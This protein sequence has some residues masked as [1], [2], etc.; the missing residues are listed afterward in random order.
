[1]HSTHEAELDIPSLPIAA[2]RVHIVPALHTTSILSMGQL[3][4][5]G[6]IVTFDATTVQ[7]HRNTELLLTGIRTP[8]TGLW[9]LSLV[10]PTPTTS[11]PDFLHQSY[12]AVQSATPAELVA[13]AHATLLSPALSTLKYALDLGFLPNFIGLTAKSLLKHP[14]T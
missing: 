2:R 9:H 14:P 12:A 13:F 8:A 4:D 11:V 3:C 6:C 10:A 7:V 5:A 1:M